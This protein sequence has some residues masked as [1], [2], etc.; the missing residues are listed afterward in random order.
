MLREFSDHFTTLTPEFWLQ[1]C[2]DIKDFRNTFQLP[3]NQPISVDDCNVHNSLHIEELVE[4]A[5]A[6]NKAEQADA[7]L[8]AIYTLVGRTAQVGDYDMKT[9]SVAHVVDILLSTAATLKIPY[10]ACWDAIHASNMTKAA[11]SI[12]EALDTIEHYKNRGIAGEF[13]VSESGKF[14]VKCSED[15]TDETG[16][17]IR[18][19]KVLKSVQYTPVD[20]EKV[21]LEN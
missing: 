10:K 16:S 18:K 13:F 15:S 14:L 2:H 20:L 1:M 4:L 19:G 21:L 17:T 7:I 9:S 8:D 3:V 12:E 6:T 11:S 5:L